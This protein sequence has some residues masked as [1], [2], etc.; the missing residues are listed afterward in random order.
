MRKGYK[1]T[2]TIKKTTRYYTDS[3][4]TYINEKEKE[5]I[6]DYIFSFT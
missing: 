5:Q 2:G 4:Y 3:T 1:I 6:T